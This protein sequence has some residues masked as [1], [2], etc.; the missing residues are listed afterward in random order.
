MVLQTSMKT[1]GTDY[2]P[3][4]EAIKTAFENEEKLRITSIEGEAR[5][6]KFLLHGIPLSCTMDDVALSIQQS[7]PGVLKLAQTPRWL[8][9]DA[10]RQASGKGMSTVVLSVAGQHTLQ[11]LGYQYLFVCNSRCRLARYLPFGPSSQ[12]GKCCKFGHP[13]AMCRN[14]KPT[15]GVCGKEHFTRHHECPAPDCNGGGR[16]TH[17]PMHCTN[18]NNSLHTSI[19]PLCPARAIARQRNL[20]L[21]ATTEFDS[22]VQLD[23]PTSENTPHHDNMES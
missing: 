11:S 10:K 9:T 20:N 13:T 5:W 14:E 2:M 18:C 17:T 22:E 21:G 4:L 16:C 19:N 3:Y 6:S 8:T 15:C 1:R 7:Y 12:C 23:N